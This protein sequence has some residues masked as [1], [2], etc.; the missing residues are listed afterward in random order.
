M[1]DIICV[2]FKCNFLLLAQ[3]RELEHCIYDVFASRY[4]DSSFGILKIT[5]GALFYLIK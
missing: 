4:V 3:I 5:R 2:N 1:N